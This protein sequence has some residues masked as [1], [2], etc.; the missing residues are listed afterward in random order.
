MAQKVIITD[1][2]DG[3]RVMSNIRNKKGI[4][5]F[6]ENDTYTAT[7]VVTWFDGSPMDDSKVDGKIYLKHRQS[8]SYYLVNLPNW[9]ETFLQ[10]PNVASLRNMSSTEIL[11]LRMGYY[12][13]VTLLGYYAENGGDTPA[14]IEYYL[15]DTAEEDDGGSVFEVGGIKLE[16]EF[17]GEVDVRYFGA[18]ADGVFDNTTSITRASRYSKRIS[19]TG[20]LASNIKLTV[21]KA[22]S[23]Y[24]FSETIQIDDNI[25]FI[26]EGRL[27]YDGVKNKSAIV[28]GY[29]SVRSFNTNIKVSLSTLRDSTWEDPEFVGVRTYNNTVSSIEV[30]LIDGFYKG[31]ECLGDGAG[32]AYNKI[33]LQTLNSNK[34][35]IYLDYLNDGWCNENTF[36]NGR[37]SATT[38][39][40]AGKTRVGA[41]LT[42]DNNRM[43]MPSFE[44]NVLTSSP[45]QAHA[46]ILDDAIQ[47]KIIHCRN[48]GNSSF[49]YTPGKGYAFI[50]N[51]NTKNCLIEVAYTDDRQRGKE[52][53]AFQDN[54]LSKQNRFVA[55]E[56]MWSEVNFGNLLYDSGYLPSKFTATSPTSAS[57]PGVMFIS[58]TGVLSTF[59][60][61]PIKLVNNRNN[62]TS[63][64]VE[65]SGQGI[66]VS[67][68]T[69][70]N[71]KLAVLRD[72]LNGRS[73]RVGLKFYD[74]QGVEITSST[75][76]MIDDQSLNGVP[77][78]IF[79]YN[80][81]YGGCYLT[82]APAPAN[83]PVYFS[84]KDDVK[85]VVLFIANPS[86]LTS[87]KSFQILGLENSFR[88]S[89]VSSSS[90]NSDN[91]KRAL[92]NI[93]SGTFRTGE[94]VFQ[95]NPTTGNPLI[96]LCNRSGTANDINITGDYS[97]GRLITNVSD[98]DKV[99]IGDFINV[100]G[101]SGLQYTITGIDRTNNTITINSST[102]ASPGVSLQ[103]TNDPPNWRTGLF[104]EMTKV[105][106][107][108][109][110]GVI[111]GVTG[112]IHQTVSTG[113]VDYPLFVKTSP[114]GSS[115]WRAV[116]LSESVSPSPDTAE[117]AAGATPTKAEFDALLAELRDLK[118][119]MRSG[120]API[121]AT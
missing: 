42:G 109:P 115:G 6:R 87:I 44:L 105:S 71:K 43:L 100:Q 36:Y 85:S 31:L 104:L 120:D 30:T 68:N 66:A 61:N 20:T 32:F 110:E 95:Q 113:P 12:K 3:S 121:L 64:Y 15:S 59:A 63:G 89:A 60:S 13:G 29:P 22:L 26:C 96:Y 79:E 7:R 10:K 83:I 39:F 77:N 97:S 25:D 118:S 111:E 53:N 108:S 84:V 52:A 91:N 72:A 45:G 27:R 33:F 119:K 67:I 69:E 14:P 24:S 82:G 9:G 5:F 103:I 73:G 23:F 117:Q 78:Q 112:A 54:S 49:N 47:N 37:F 8:G 101:F 38:G 51:G 70:Y 94:L 80:T 102:G 88:N 106:G 1:Y 107:A 48:E 4:P 75:I 93:T 86:T 50:A 74:A 99:N 56:S 46:V 57:I 41:R 81:S 19:N 16:H 92:G 62:Q 28:I 11:L 98:I 40:N 58:T 21:P 2:P 34:Y 18:R 55:V 116:V 90:I 35:G 76:S 114:T 17:V 65:Y